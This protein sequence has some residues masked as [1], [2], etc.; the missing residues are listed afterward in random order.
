M[1]NNKLIV[2][3]AAKKYGSVAFLCVAF[4]YGGIKK[5]LKRSFGISVS[6]AEKHMCRFAIVSQKW[7][8]VYLS[9]F[10]SFVV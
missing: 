5:S 7:T 2:S 10:S 4:K 8:S 6:E 9:S 3:V 1:T